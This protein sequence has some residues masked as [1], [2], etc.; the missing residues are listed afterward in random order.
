MGE[1]TAE[2]TQLRWT[3]LKEVNEAQTGLVNPDKV[4]AALEALAKSPPKPAATDIVVPGSPT[5]LKQMEQ[6]AAAAPAPLPRPGPRG[7]LHRPL[8]RR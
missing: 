5:F 7:R 3:N 4:N 2:A 8:P 1:F 6:A